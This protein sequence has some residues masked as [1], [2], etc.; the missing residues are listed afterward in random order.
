MSLYE[1]KRNLISF[2]YPNRCPFCDR[3][4]AAGEFFYTDCAAALDF[5]ENSNKD[6]FCC[7]YNEKSKPLLIKAKENAD[8]YAVS[9][10]AKLL[11][12]A[13]VRNNVLH[14]IDI[15]TVI[16][17][18]KA[19]LKE[20]GYSFPALL[21]RELASLCEKQFSGK[22]LIFLREIKEQKELSAKEREENLKGALGI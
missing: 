6:T 16:P 2:V 18:R 7:V 22:M 3:V 5:C 8:G 4:I 10:C 11:H 14:K 13:L 17:A 21:A 19:A 15:I 9:A 20:R 12:D 1:L